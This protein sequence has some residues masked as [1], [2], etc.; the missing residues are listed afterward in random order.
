M[1][2]EGVLD[3]VA[4]TLGLRTADASVIREE[5]GAPSGRRRLPPPP[6]RFPALCG[7]SLGAAAAAAH[8]LAGGR[9]QLACAAP[10]PAPPLAAAHMPRPPRPPLPPLPAAVKTQGQAVREATIEGFKGA[11]LAVAASSVTVLGACKL[12]P[13]FNR[14]LSVSGKTALIVRA[15][16]GQGAGCQ[17]GVPPGPG[18]R[19]AGP[20]G[21]GAAGSAGCS[22]R[23]GSWKGSG[24]WLLPPPGRC[25]APTCAAARGPG[26]RRPPRR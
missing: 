21:A 25:P 18:R 2:A 15:C 10:R 9:A 13:R 6:L 16:G 3:R 17:Q 7:A 20:G 22:H 19:L 5:D 23:E 8:G 12:F 26:R 1:P 11:G 14:S 4:Q 24:R